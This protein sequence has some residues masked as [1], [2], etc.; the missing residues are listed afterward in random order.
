MKWHEG[1]SHIAPGKFSFADTV[2]VKNQD[3]RAVSR[4]R[5]KIHKQGLVNEQA[6]NKQKIEM[7]N[8]NYQGAKKQM[9]Q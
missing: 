7:Q 2:Q 8:F 9:E 5:L 3:E 6:Q 1:K 4:E